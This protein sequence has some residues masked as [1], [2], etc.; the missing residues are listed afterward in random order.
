[1]TDEFLH[2]GPERIG[3]WIVVGRLGSG[4]AANV[5]RCRKGDQEVAIKLLRT[6]LGDAPAGD[7]PGRQPSQL[8]RRLTREAEILMRLDHPHVVKIRQ[9]ELSADPAWIVMDYVAGRHAGFA[10]RSGPTTPTLVRRLGR[11]LLSAM[12][13]WHGIGVAHRDLKP[14]NLILAP[15]WD[16][17][18]VDFGLA[19]DE[20]QERLSAIGVRVGTCAYA[21]PE[22]VSMDAGEARSWDLYGAGQ[23]LFELLVGRRA[24]DPK[25]GALQIMR[26]KLARPAL[27]PGPEVPPDLRDVVVRLTSREADR[28]PKT[29]AEA[30]AGLRP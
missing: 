28:R 23:V 10:I 5:F 18:V 26:E 7:G 22:W 3:D 8:L 19:L 16:V 2:D 4:G 1:M 15:S 14:G 27:D 9:V 17:V 13:H 24:F 20:S 6:G 25:A 11:Q 12:D 30:L 21:P 29:A